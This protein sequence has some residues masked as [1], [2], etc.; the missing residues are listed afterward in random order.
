[1]EGL[2]SPRTPRR[3]HG[4][5]VLQFCLEA[6]SGSAARD[7]DPLQGRICPSEVE[8][9]QRPEG[10]HSRDFSRRC[11]RPRLPAPPDHARFAN[12]CRSRPFQSAD[13][14]ALGKWPRGSGSGR[15]ESV[16]SA[17]HST[18]GPRCRATNLRSSGHGA[19][20]ARE[21]RTPRGVPTT[22]SNVLHPRR[23]PPSVHPP[24]DPLSPPRDRSNGLLARGR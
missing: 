10:R 22:P 17:T 20:L 9:C 2:S 24:S 1:M 23:H 5:P 16:H 11:R 14:G 3:V 18:E 8:I 15:V 7:P 13:A 12:G 19:E 21:N 4:A 6:H